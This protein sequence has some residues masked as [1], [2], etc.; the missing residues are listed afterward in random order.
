LGQPSTVWAWNG[1][2]NLFPLSI[3]L[4]NNMSI[5]IGVEVALI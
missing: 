2:S 3:H 4:L 5:H 1:W